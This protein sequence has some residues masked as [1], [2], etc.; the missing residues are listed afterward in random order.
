MHTLTVSYYLLHHPSLYCFHKN[1]NACPPKHKAQKN[2]TWWKIS[3]MV[4]WKRDIKSFIVEQLLT[5][6]YSSS[7]YSDECSHRCALPYQDW[8]TIRITA[9]FLRWCP[10][11]TVDLSFLVHSGC[12]LVV[13]SLKVFRT[14]T[15]TLIALLWVH[16]GK[17]NRSI[18]TRRSSQTTH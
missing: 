9:S 2:K 15:F 3:L 17:L 12:L 5:F 14:F 18:S 1:F 10:L 11:L 4:V 6:F 7:F 13:Q 16:I 8:K